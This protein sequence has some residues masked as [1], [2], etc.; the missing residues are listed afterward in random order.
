[1]SIIVSHTKV[2]RAYPH[3]AVIFDDEEDFVQTAR[4]SQVPSEKPVKT[5]ADAKRHM[6]DAFNNITKI[7]TQDDYVIGESE[8]IDA[9]AD[10]LGWNGGVK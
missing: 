7:I 4:F 9:K 5:L 2:G 3:I 6:F 8:L 10:K 1:M